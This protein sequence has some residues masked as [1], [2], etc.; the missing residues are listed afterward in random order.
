[1]IKPWERLFFAVIGVAALFVAYL[2][3]LVPARMDRVFTWADLPPLHARFVGVLYFF[4]ALYML[5]CVVARRAGQVRPAMAGIGLFTSLLL[6]VTLLN[7]EAFDFDLL[8]VWVWTLSYIVYPLIALTLALTWRGRDRDDAAPSGADAL[9]P[10][11]RT[12]LLVQAC[13]FAF[14]GRRRSWPGRR[15]STRGPGPSPPAW[16]SSTGARSWPTPTAAGPTAG[17]A[18]GPR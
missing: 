12:F 11:A 4:G 9:A 17:G 18:G 14:S 5:G 2:G 15:W 13:V 16:R 10:W 1:M 3:L 8:P 7:L 6:V